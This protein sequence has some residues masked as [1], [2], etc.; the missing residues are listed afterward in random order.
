MVGYLIFFND[1]PDNFSGRRLWTA[2][3][4]VKHTDCLWSQTDILLEYTWSS[5][6]EIVLMEAYVP[7]EVLWRLHQLCLQPPPPMPWAVLHKPYHPTFLFHLWNVEFD[8][9]PLPSVELFDHKTHFYCHSFHL[10]WAWYSSR[11]CSVTL[12][13]WS[14]SEP[15]WLCQSE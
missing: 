7:L 9:N 14:T 8:A 6:E 2:D 13:F 12:I 15:T 11:L 4:P 5:W 10:R 1:A 3:R